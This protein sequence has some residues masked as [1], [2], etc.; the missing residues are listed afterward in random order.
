MAFCNSLV[1]A[2]QAG[3]G[4]SI[5]ALFLLGASRPRSLL[6]VL[7][8]AAFDTAYRI[9]H[10]RRL[11]TENVQVM[12]ALLDL[13]ACA[14]RM[15]DRKGFRKIEFDQLRE[16][17]KTLSAD[18]LMSDYLRRLNALENNR[19]SKAS[20][21]DSC[22]VRQYREDVIAVSLGVLVAVSES[23]WSNRCIPRVVSLE[24]GMDQLEK[25]ESFRFLFR[26]AMLCQIIDDVM[27]YDAD[28][29]SQL[30]GFLTWETNLAE[31]IQLADSAACDYGNDLASECERSVDAVDLNSGQRVFFQSLI[32]PLWILARMLLWLARGRAIW[33]NWKLRRLSRS[34]N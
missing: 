7:C 2:T 17:V 29:K 34:S 28:R 15:Y 33:E 24:G 30:P 10:S 9:L 18:S 1:D 16:F 11:P 25:S 31:A 6:R 8:V 13:G 22:K 27:D 19:P 14:N 4:S 32:F 5:R 3:V 26:M 23:T 21:N 12:S 20:F